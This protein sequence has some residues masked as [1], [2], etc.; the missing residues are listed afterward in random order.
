MGKLKSG[1]EGM[2]KLSL[3]ISIVVAILMGVGIGMLMKTYIGYD[4]LLWLGVFW[5]VAAAGL[6]VK[7]AYDKLKKEMNELAENPR[8]KNY[9]QP[10]NKK[11]DDDDDD[12][13]DTKGY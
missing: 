8:Y 6:N 2:E 7:K 11:I 4:W 1:I 13:D 5:G 9:M 3:G 12:I 10:D